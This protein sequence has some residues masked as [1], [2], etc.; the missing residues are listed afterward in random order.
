MCTPLQVLPGAANDQL[1]GHREAIPQ[2]IRGAV[3]PDGLHDPYHI[4]VAHHGM[5]DYHLL[6]IY[7]S[8]FHLSGMEQLFNMCDRNIQS[9]QMKELPKVSR[10]RDDPM[11][12]WVSIHVSYVQV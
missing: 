3:V 5:V 10:H 6:P 1:E 12:Q 9:S 8:P 2:P 7:V 4:D 11:L